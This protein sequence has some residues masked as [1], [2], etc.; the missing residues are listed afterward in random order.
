MR[1]ATPQRGG[2]LIGCRRRGQALRIAVWDTGCGI[3][4]DRRDDVFREFVQLDGAGTRRRRRVGARGSGWGCRSSRAWPSCSALRIE[5]RSTR[6]PRLD[7]RVRAA[8]GTRDARRRRRCRR[9]RRRTR[10]ARHLRA[11]D[12][13]RRSRRVPACAG[14]SQTWGCLTLG[15]RASLHPPRSTLPWPVQTLCRRQVDASRP[16]TQPDRAS[17][18][19]HPRCSMIYGMPKPSRSIVELHA[20]RCPRSATHGHDDPDRHSTGA[21][22]RKRL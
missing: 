8:A 14:C 4:D 5:L 19:Q 17:V 21:V 18:L 15:R 11:R 2:V 3:P 7:V 1:S 22:S 12:R 16:S 6:R 13:R 10:P 9:C 20:A